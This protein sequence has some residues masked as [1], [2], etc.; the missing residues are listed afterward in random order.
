MEFKKLNLLYHT[1]L[2]EFKKAIL[3]LRKVLNQAKIRIFYYIFNCI[4]PSA[5]PVFIITEPRCGTTLFGGFLN[6]IKELSYKDEILNSNFPIGINPEKSNPQK[7]LKHIF[8]TMHAHFKSVVAAK[9]FFWHLEIFSLKPDDFK[10]LFPNAKFIIIYR[11]DIGKQYVSFRMAHRTKVWALKGKNKINGAIKLEIK[12]EDLL[13]F[14]EK[15]RNKYRSLLNINWLHPNSIIVSY[16]ELIED[17]QKLFNEK[18]FPFLGLQPCKIYSDYRKINPKPI[19]DK[20]SNY[21]SVK[22]IFE[23]DTSIQ[24]Y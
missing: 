5:A 2:S 20:V 10:K 8:Y 22:Y 14:I 17:P 23:S 18:I 16:E 24:K 1:F 13:K 19:S 3:P 11:C 6:S 15:T 12:K 21:D 9:I 7:T 4:K